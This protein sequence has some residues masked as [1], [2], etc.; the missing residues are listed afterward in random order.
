[1][2][3]VARAMGACVPPCERTGA[4]AS[5]ATLVDPARRRWVACAG[6]AAFGLL[7]VAAPA[8]LRAEESSTEVLAAEDLMRE[9]G[10]LRRALLVYAQAADQLVRNASV[11][12]DALQRT[13]TLFRRFGEDYHEQKLEEAHVFPVLAAGDGA[14]AALVKT[15]VA[16]H[17][18]G[19]E[20]TDYVI[21]TTRGGSIGR[22]D[23]QPLAGVLKDFVRMYEHHAAIEDTVVFPAWK[24][25]LSSSRYRALS[26]QFEDLEQRMFGKDGFE[27]AV[28]RIAAVEQR[29]GLADLAALTAAVPPAYRRRT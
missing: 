17:R 9:H 14:H 1:M 24:R 25:S 6:T 5:P 28:A 21:A 26:G 19:R 7:A 11:P 13:A 16:Q 27:D 10:V 18:R 29:M 12:A 8:A 23:A 20:I 3:T 15:L 2:K 22:S 4:N